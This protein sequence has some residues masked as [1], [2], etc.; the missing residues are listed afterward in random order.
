MTVLRRGDLFTIITQKQ[1]NSTRIILDK[2][3]LIP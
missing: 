1:I 2:T 3:G